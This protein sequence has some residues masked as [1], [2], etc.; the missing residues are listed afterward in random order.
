MSEKNIKLSTTHVFPPIPIRQFDWEAMDYEAF[1]CP[2]CSYIVGRGATENEALADAIEQ[3][4]DELDPFI[5]A[6]EWAI[7]DGCDRFIELAP[8]GFD[9]DHICRGNA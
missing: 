8:D 1:C 7:C 4:L 2:E 6:P 9:H 3:Y 5:S